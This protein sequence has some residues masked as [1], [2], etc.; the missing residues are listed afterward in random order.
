MKKFTQEEFHIVAKECE[1]LKKFED[2]FNVAVSL[3]KK[4]RTNDKALILKI[5]DIWEELKN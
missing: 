4:G 2:K 1:R 5:I 3:W